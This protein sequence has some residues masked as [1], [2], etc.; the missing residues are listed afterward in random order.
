MN[1][2]VKSIVEQLELQDHPEGGFY[3]EVYRSSGEIPQKV[4]PEDFDGNRNYCTSIYF[5]LTSENFSAFHRINQDEIWHFYQGSGLTIHEIDKEGNYIAHRLGNDLSQ[6]EPQLTIKAR[7][8]FA[9]E[10]S[11]P[12]SFALVGC[13][14]A[15][16]FDF[17]D[18]ELGKADELSDTYPDQADL[19]S[20]LCRQ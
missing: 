9:S 15:P 13:T 20:R 6:Q 19:F 3:K 11:E 1:E 2:T 7:S 17:A 8:W 4:L 10:V 14:V 12:N 16:G 18:F 5:L